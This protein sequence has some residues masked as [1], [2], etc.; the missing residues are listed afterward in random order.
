ML[1]I[2]FAVMNSNRLLVV[3]L[4]CDKRSGVSR[5]DVFVTSKVGPGGVPFPLGFN[6]TMAQ[7]K[8]I[9]SLPVYPELEQ[10][11][12]EHVANSVR[13]FYDAVSL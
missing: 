5:S 12:L 8:R 1:S 10:T 3:L 13:S 11:E 7:A 9:L 2:S 6:E 4:N